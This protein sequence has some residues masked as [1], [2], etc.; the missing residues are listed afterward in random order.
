MKVQRRRDLVTD[1]L[2]RD[3]QTAVLVRGR[4]V[5]LSDVGA[6]VFALTEEPVEVEWLAARLESQFG[7]PADG[8]VLDA[9]KDA[10]T[11]LIRLGVLRRSA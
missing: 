10:V 8:S 4:L 2:A 6:M 11:E 9:T 5:R 7:A 1:W 3:G